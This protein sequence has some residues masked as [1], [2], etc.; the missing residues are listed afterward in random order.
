LERYAALFLAVG[1]IHYKVSN[2][3]TFA[4]LL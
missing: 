3:N 2:P 4:E 1:N